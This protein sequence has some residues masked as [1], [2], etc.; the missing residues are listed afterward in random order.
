M[1]SL[2]MSGA[3][4][5]N[6]NGWLANTPCAAS[7]AVLDC[8]YNLTALQV[9][10]DGGMGLAVVWVFVPVLPL[11]FPPVTTLEGVLCC[12]MCCM[13]I[14]LCACGWFEQIETMTSPDW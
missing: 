14:W 10:G 1:L 6:T 12:C 4:A 13:T 5:Q 2:N 3:V 7:P 11:F 8:I 9:P